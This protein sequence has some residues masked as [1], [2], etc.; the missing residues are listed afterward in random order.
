[1]T[2]WKFFTAWLLFLLLCIALSYIWARVRSV[3]HP[4]NR[5]LDTLFAGRRRPFEYAA[6]MAVALLITWA[7]WKA[8][9]PW[10]HE[11]VAPKS[12]TAPVII[13]L[14]PDAR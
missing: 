4:F 14:N 1:M 7:S 6:L 12:T 2:T 13:K 3:P 10:W 8:A 9:R 11:P 5:S